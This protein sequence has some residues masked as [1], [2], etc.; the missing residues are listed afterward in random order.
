VVVALSEELHFG[1]AAARLHVVQSAVSQALKDLEAELGVALFERSPRGVT[2]TAAGTHFRDHAL[3]AMEEIASGASAARRA[4]R[5]QEGR[6]RVAFVA[7]ATSTALPRVVTRFM[8][9]APNVQVELENTSS[10]GV[11][12]AIARREADVGIVPEIRRYGSLSFFELRRERLVAVLPPDHDLASGRRKTLAIRK[13][14]GQA[15]IE[16]SGRKEPTLHA[17]Q[18][19]LLATHHVRPRVAFEFDEVETMLSMVA[20]GLGIGI[21]PASL[22][23]SFSGGVACRLLTPKV[24]AEHFLVWD[25]K[26][27]SPAALRFV[28][29]FQAEGG[30]APRPRAARGRGAPSAPRD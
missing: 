24:M 8:R 25:P 14:D 1:R 5:G 19:A 4:A 26:T 18:R 10:P 28:H 15:L 23:K 16:A 3:R 11:V 29:L 20:A 30:Q 22:A 21:V 6:L 9:E 7:M 2:I 17:K 27:I 13:L 12:E